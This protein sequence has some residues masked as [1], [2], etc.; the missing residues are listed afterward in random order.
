MIWM[1]NEL[2]QA[3]EI[4]FKNFRHIHTTVQVLEMI[5]MLK[6]TISNIWNGYSMYIDYKQKIGCIVV[7]NYINKAKYLL[8]L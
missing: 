3:N 6:W 7:I 1:L 2:I 8:I 4:F 5:F